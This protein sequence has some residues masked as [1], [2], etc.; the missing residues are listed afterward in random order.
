MN[1]FLWVSYASAISCLV[2]GLSKGITP[3]LAFN[4]NT[5]SIVFTIGVMILGFSFAKTSG[6]FSRKEDVVLDADYDEE[7]HNDFSKVGSGTDIIQVKPEDHT[8]ASF[9]QGLPT[10]SIQDVKKINN[11]SED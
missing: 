9:A 11:D 2:F 3:L 7:F 5:K 6:L 8:M 1:T 10:E 4:G